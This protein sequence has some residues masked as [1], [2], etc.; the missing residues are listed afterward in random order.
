MIRFRK[1]GE[2]LEKAGWRWKRKRKEKDG[3]LNIWGTHYRKM[4]HRSADKKEGKKSGGSNGAG[5]GKRKMRF[6]KE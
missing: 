5:V 2:K 6:R 4:R 1:G 3:E